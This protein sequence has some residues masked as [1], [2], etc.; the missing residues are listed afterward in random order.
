MKENIEQ[1]NIKNNQQAI[2]FLKS[3][4]PDLPD[5]MKED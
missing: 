2:V 4:L 3:K 5:N 1:T